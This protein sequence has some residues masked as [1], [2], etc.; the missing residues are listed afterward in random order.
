VLCRRQRAI[1]ALLASGICYELAWFFV[2]PTG[3]FRYSQWMVLCCGIAAAQW[4]GRSYSNDT[5]RPSAH[6]DASQATSA[7]LA[8]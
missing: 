8:P 2:D 4:L 6:R 5:T 1:V 7:K 3:D